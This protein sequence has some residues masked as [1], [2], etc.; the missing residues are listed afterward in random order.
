MPTE[1][2]PGGPRRSSLRNRILLAVVASMALL[3]VAVI[4]QG[5]V[6]NEY[7]ER[8]VWKTLLDGELDHL[9]ERHREEPGYRWVD[10]DN[11]ALYGGPGGAPIPPALTGYGPGLHDDILVGGRDTVL[12]VRDIDDR[13][14]MLALDAEPL[15][16]RERE[17]AAVIIAAALTTLL[18][19]TLAIGWIVARLMRPLDA[20][21][22]RI[23]AIQPERTDRRVPVPPH[24]S[25]EVAVIADAFNQFIDRSD[26]FVD[27]ERGF[28]NQASHELRTP[29]AVIA[30]AATLAASEPGLPDAARGQLERI[31]RTAREVEQLV[32]LLLVLAKDPARLA[33]ASGPIRLDA[34]LPEIV[35]QH[36]HLAEGKDLAIDVD[37]LAPVTL[38]A[39][40][41]IVQAAVGNLLRNAVENSDRGRV[42]VRLEHP[43]RVLIEDPGHGM[44][45]EEISAI[46]ARLAREGGGHDGG[47]IGLTLIARLCEHLDWRLDIASDHGQGTTTVLDFRPGDAP[48]PR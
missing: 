11:I 19:A 23:A 15:E 43:A 38:V 7:V 5:L 3:S 9:L 16:A 25:R 17:L 48:A 40:L 46:Y 34:L 18:L 41:P 32:S 42:R 39:P 47:G 22:G 10:S 14:V 13:P 36:R 29:I 28:I 30:G 35:D 4:F 27:R 31:Q 2:T 26:R 21:A 6:V 1:A 20:I 8:I 24:A 12:L 45:P 44:S 33:D 37:A